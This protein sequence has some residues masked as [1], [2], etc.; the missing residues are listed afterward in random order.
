MVDAEYY[1]VNRIT[2]TNDVITIECSN[3]NL[4][5][6]S[7]LI[8]YKKRVFIVVYVEN[9]YNGAYFARC[10]VLNGLYT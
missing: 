7:E 8:R 5:L 4:P 6:R 2:V 1:A 10:D 9:M 3:K